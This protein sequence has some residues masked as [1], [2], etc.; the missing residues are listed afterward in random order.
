MR[1]QDTVRR[2]RELFQ[3]AA[4]RHGLVLVDP[5]RLRGY[6][7]IRLAAEPSRPAHS[8]PLRIVA[9]K[10]AALTVHARDEHVEDLVLGYVWH[11]HDSPRFFLLTYAEA[12]PIFGDE[13]STRRKMAEHRGY[14]SN[15]NL[16]LA[17]QAQMARFEDRW[18]W[19]RD[20]LLRGSLR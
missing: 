1:E 16:H 3:G 11:V 19:L 4:A 12:L 18:E 15:S 6:H 14:W 5:E 2:A 17:G 13:Q 10:G 8:L 7:R 20:A 9:A